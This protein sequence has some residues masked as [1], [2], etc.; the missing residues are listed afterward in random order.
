[1]TA[2]RDAERDRL[3]A[4]ARRAGP[5]LEAAIPMSG[6]GWPG[7]HAAAVHLDD[8]GDMVAEHG[9]WERS[10]GLQGDR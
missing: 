1:M 9:S 7:V 4:A 2:D 8:A 10:P 6:P 3:L 5:A